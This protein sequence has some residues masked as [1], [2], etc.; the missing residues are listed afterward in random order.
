MN[1][2]LQGFTLV[3]LLVVITIVAILSAVVLVALNPALRFQNARDSVRANDVQELL[4]AI[5]LDEVDNGGTLHTNISSLTADQ[6]YMIGTGMSAGCD[7]NNTNCDVDMGTDGHCVDLSFLQTEG[8]M[9]EM[10]ISPSNVVTWDD[11]SANGEEGT[12]YVLEREG[13]DTVVHV[14]ACESENTTTI[15]ASR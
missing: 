3:E 14:Y 10:P 4:T 6:F 1:K 7:D 5:K 12:G 9:A 13:V 15:S 2:N 11:G 8:Y